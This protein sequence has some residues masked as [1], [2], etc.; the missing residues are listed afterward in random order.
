M[1]S[2]KTETTG[3][4]KQL[5]LLVSGLGGSFL[6]ILFFFLAGSLYQEGGSTMINHARQEI[7]GN[8]PQSIQI[9]L[10]EQAQA[11]SIPLESGSQAYWYIAR[12]GGVV[13]YL[14]LWLA[15]CWGILMSSKLIKGYINIA[16]AFALHEFLPILGVIFAA[17]HALVLLGDS[18]IGFNIQQILIPFTSSYKPGWTGL[19]S[20][21]F[22]LF[23]AIIISFYVRKQ[24]GQKSW[25]LFHYISFLAFLFALLH[26]LM[27]GTDSGTLAMRALYI[28]TGGITLFLIYY[29]VL[30]HAPR[31]MRDRQ[32]RA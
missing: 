9:T 32:S 27:A 7:T 2:R 23:L 11:M 3:N 31:T 24:I 4:N 15:T 26:G 12:A 22:Y 18:F 19:G 30:A 28:V 21:A 8:I 25:R 5:L 20:L 29:R 6:L 16:T 14:L 17:I 1:L 10:A 13:A